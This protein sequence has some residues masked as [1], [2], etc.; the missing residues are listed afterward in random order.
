MLTVDFDR[1]RIQP[2]ERV[3][4]LGCGAGRHAFEALRRG[5]RVVAADVA[6]RELP[7]VMR[8]IDAMRLAGEAGAEGSA[9][10]VRADALALPFADDAFDAVIASEILEHVPL[11][12]DAI[13]EIG[14]VLRPGGVAAVTVP[15]WFPERVCW[16]LSER[17]HRVEGGHLRVYSRRTLRTR[18]ASAGL[19]ATDAHHAHALHSPYW[20]LK[21]IVGVE[22][23][24]HPFVRAYHRM[25]VWDIERRPRVTR[26]LE[27]ALNP[28][29][30][31][32]L[33]VYLRKP[34][35]SARP[36]LP[37]RPERTVVGVAS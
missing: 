12:A 10:A 16:L 21:C 6:E 2:G 30:G 1:L 35:A 11:D 28:L 33:V 31:K 26:A 8:M 15:R 3:L 20:W 29:I 18:L 4:D 22:R 23:D 13:R 7:G 14:R 27:R 5:G 37:A 19:V 32:S 9:S 17:Y 25:L 34:A 24:D 36:P